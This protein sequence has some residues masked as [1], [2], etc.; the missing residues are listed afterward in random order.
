MT[1][2]L[3]EQVTD[4]EN[5]FGVGIEPNSKSIIGSQ[6]VPYIYEDRISRE[7]FLAAL[8]KIHNMT[9][10]ERKSIGQ[11]G[12]DHVLK[13]YNYDD[14]CNKWVQ[15][16]DGACEKHGSWFRVRNRSTNFYCCS[17]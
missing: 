12:R 8:H 5:W 3:Q 14:Y 9:Q 15:I 4:G 16:I 17:S 1:G 6:D 2:G 10:E 13:N 11:A 7:D